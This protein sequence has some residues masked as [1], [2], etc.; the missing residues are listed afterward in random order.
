M[1]KHPPKLT[2]SMKALLNW[3]IQIGFSNSIIVVIERRHSTDRQ[4]T[5]NPPVLRAMI[6]GKTIRHECKGIAGVVRHGR[7]LEEKRVY[8]AR[9]RRRNN[10]SRFINTNRR[11]LLLSL[12]APG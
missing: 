11:Y 3:D 4:I 8:A 5:A 1:S 9:R 12:H 10:M 2:P 6:N 7:C